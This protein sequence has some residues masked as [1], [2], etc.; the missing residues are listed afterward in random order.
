MTERSQGLSA[1][2]S[3]LFFLAGV[4]V[5]GVFFALG[6]LVGYN[7]RA[8]AVAAD[9]ERVTGPAAV[10]PVVNP[11]PEST[12]PATQE[13]SSHPSSDS[14]PPVSEEVIPPPPAQKTAPSG[15]SRRGPSPPGAR[16]AHYPSRGGPSPASE[17]PSWAVQVVASSSRQDAANLVKALKPRG[18]SASLLTPEQARA[19]DRF[20]RVVVGPFNSRQEAEKVRQKL[21]DEGFKPFIRVNEPNE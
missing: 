14:N 2:H 20:F 18:Y 10:P 13:A 8:P 16:A 3:I 17:K 4:A 9:S 15:Q 7:E 11:P 5:C 1:R 6:F 19:G 21:A 12:K